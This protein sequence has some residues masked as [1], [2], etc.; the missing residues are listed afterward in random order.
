MHETH[1]DWCV[2]LSPVLLCYLI[3]KWSLATLCSQ[4]SLTFG[5]DQNKSVP[6][7]EEFRVHWSSRGQEACGPS[8][9]THEESLDRQSP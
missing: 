7:C 9:E 4:P 2:G 6:G 8:D 3:Q 1:F 5:A